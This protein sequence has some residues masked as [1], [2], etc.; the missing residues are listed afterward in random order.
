MVAE[1]RL[2]VCVTVLSV[3][4]KAGCCLHGYRGGV[5]VPRHW[6]HTA[7]QAARQAEQIRMRSLSGPPGLLSLSLCHHD[8]AASLK[9]HVSDFSGRTVWSKLILLL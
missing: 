5:L 8:T 4:W 6:K 2:C 7:K 3:P 1:A 9:G